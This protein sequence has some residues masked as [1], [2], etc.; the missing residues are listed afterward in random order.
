MTLSLSACGGGPTAV[1]GWRMVDRTLDVKIDQ[2]GVGDTD[3][4]GT[5]GVTD[6]YDNA[7]GPLVRGVNG[8]ISTKFPQDGRY[9]VVLDGCGSM[10]AL[11]YDWLVDISPLI[12]STACEI[13]VRLTEGPH[14]VA[15]TVRDASGKARCN[16]W[17][18]NRTRWLVTVR[19]RGVNS[20][21]S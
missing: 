1:I 13:R 20:F 11:S 6:D 10:G 15:L 9:E 5:D 3:I 12:R 2:P 14:D 17:A 8:N 18:P 7:Q 21:S 16:T 19:S 4:Q